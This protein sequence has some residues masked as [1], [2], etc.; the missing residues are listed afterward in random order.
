MTCYTWCQG[1]PDIDAG[2]AGQRG[3]HREDVLGKRVGVA[4]GNVGHVSETGDE[5]RHGP[6]GDW[7][8]GAA[9]EVHQLRQNPLEDHFRGHLGGQPLEDLQTEELA[10]GQDQGPDTADDHIGDHQQTSSIN[11][12]TGVTGVKE[13]LE[14]S[15]EH[16]NIR[17]QKC[18]KIFRKNF[19]SLFFLILTDGKSCFWIPVNHVC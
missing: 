16:L 12:L 1:A 2:V 8:G 5:D 13:S 9:E 11:N 17:L 6:G 10:P 18:V 7:R 19:S 14:V 15:A 4:P 3:Q